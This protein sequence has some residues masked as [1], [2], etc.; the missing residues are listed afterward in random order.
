VIAL[1]LA[2]LAARA[3]PAQ[4]TARYRIELGGV[5][6]GVAELAFACGGGDA[7]RLTWSSAM[8][9]PAAAGGQLRTKRLAGDVD[10]AGLL[11]RRRVEVDVDG[12][13]RAV[14]VPPDVAPASAAELLLAVRGGGC[15]PVVEEESGET[16]VACAELRGGE[17]RAT[18]LGVAELVT[19]GEDGFPAVVEIPSQ[20]T[21][22]VRD[23]GARV[24]EE[25]PPLEVRVPGPPRARAARTFC[26]RTPDRPAPTADPS[27]LPPA[28]PD[29][30]SCRTQAAEYVEAARSAGLAARVALGVAHDGDGF[31]WHAWAEVRTGAGWVA[32]DPAFGQLP[33]RGPRFTIA[34]HGGD[35]ASLAAAGRSILACWGTASVE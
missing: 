16:G 25:A 22:Y 4:G 24:P 35:D 12:A 15:L 1:A 19:V 11:V 3:E 26:G 21:R 5:Q 18:V 32:V 20:R 29:G 30:R 14:P 34:R 31:V 23:A 27:R 6:V 2:L 8:R 9:L 7:C 28:R 13:T 10:R 17:L 33:A